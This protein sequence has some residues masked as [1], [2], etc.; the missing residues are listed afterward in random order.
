MIVI[1]S[2]VEKGVERVAGGYPLLSAPASGF[3]GRLGAAAE[4]FPPES[5][6]QHPDTR[7]AEWQG[8]DIIRL[9][10]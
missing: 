2:E 1:E 4:G 10:G 7:T 8:I 9:I 5:I 3:V 6:L